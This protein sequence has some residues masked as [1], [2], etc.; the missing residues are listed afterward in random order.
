MS[1]PTKVRPI[2]GRR[3][4]PVMTAQ[5]TT[6][7]Q[8]TGR[9][10]KMQPEVLYVPMHLILEDMAYFAQLA[11]GQTIA[12]VLPRIVHD[13]EMEGLKN[14]LRQIRSIGIRQALVGNL[15]LLIPVRE[16]GFALR[17]DF[18]LN[19]FNSRAMMTARELEF[20]SVMLSFE[21][22]L[23]QIRDVSKPVDTEMMIY[24]RMPLMVTENCII[25]NRTGACTCNQGPVKLV[26]RTGAE[27]PIIK[28]GNGCRSV[29]LNGKKLSM[30]DRQEDLERL[31]LWG[32]RLYFTTENRQEVD[33][34]LRDFVQRAPFEPG[35]CTRGLYLRGLD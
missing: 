4:E 10:L 12:V 11:A 35:A 29:M 8:I 27:F 3:D 15:G 5:V 9:L 33:R 32:L 1:R 24:G 20:E 7:E 25:R 16:C 28:D 18:G 6:R 13:N 21:L 2:F 19:L 17:G 14:G 22:T 30:L 23:P 34:V 26:D 31:G